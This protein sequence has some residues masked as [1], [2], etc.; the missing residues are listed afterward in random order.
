MKIL[1][2]NGEEK[3]ESL[4]KSL[5]ATGHEVTAI[6]HDYGRCRR[7]SDTF[8]IVTANGDGTN[9]RV[10]RD[11]RAGRMD[12]VIALSDSDAANLLVCE[13]AKKVFHVKRTYTLAND[14]QNIGLFRTLGVDRCI[15]PA[16]LFSELIGQ[17]AL[18]NNI[19]NY[20]PIENGKVVLFEIA[21]D[22][23]SPARNKKLWEI[24]LP[25][26]SIVSCI[27][28]GDETVIP[29]GNTVLEAGDRVV[30]VSSAEAAGE[31][32]TILSGNGKRR[33]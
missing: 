1:L 3:T 2:V 22:E 7:L 17:E 32:L 15:S 31:V 10:M 13:L 16:Q 33:H 25:P 9:S 26:Q 6:E 11:A 4:I 5:I 28:R 30:V 24:G 27:L 18:E 20:L 19:R 29:Q 12:A 21:L 14:P 8:E 23:A